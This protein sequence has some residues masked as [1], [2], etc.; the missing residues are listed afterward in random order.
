MGRDIKRN[1]RKNRQDDN[2][3]EGCDQVGRQIPDEPH[4]VGDQ[5]FTILV[6]AKSTCCRVQGCEQSIL[7]VYVAL[8]QGVQEGRFSRVGVAHERGGGNPY[9][10]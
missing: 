7:R 8:G 6:Q 2:G 4:R 9:A 1:S 5:G 3:Q 10:Q